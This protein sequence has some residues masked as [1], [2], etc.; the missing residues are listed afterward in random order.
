M[1]TST[2]VP[3]MCV[4]VSVFFAADASAAT[5]GP[6]ATGLAKESSAKTAAARVAVTHLAGPRGTIAVHRSVAPSAQVAA[7]DVDSC[8]AL[9][10]A[11]PRA[12]VCM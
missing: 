1:K 5:F 9:H 3:A 6:R 8:F 7:T 10:R 12:T 4:A 2:F 11:G